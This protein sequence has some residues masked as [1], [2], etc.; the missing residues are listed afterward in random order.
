MEIAHEVEIPLG[1]RVVAV[2][3]AVVVDSRCRHIPFAMNHHESFRSLLGEGADAIEVLDGEADDEAFGTELVE[4]LARDADG[5]HTPILKQIVGSFD[6]HTERET[7]G[8]AGSATPLIVVLQ[9]LVEVGRVA[10]YAV[11]ALL[12][13]LEQ[14][15]LKGD[16]LQRDAVGK[17]RLR[18][19]L[20]SIDDS[21][22]VDLDG[23]YRC[24]RVA[25]CQHQ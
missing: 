7:G 16:V 1:A 11:V 18:K 8:V 10:H 25:L 21:V 6:E 19:I 15:V 13:G 17:R 22:L 4:Y 3:H 23:V 5:E 24:F 12:V 20:G 9:T 2:S 14:V